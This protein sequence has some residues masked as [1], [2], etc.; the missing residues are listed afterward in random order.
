[1]NR[2]LAI[3]KDGL[4]AIFF[5]FDGVLAESMNVKTEAFAKLFESYGKEIV[6]KVVKYHIENGGISRYEKIKYYYSEYL[7]KPLS[8][9]ELNAIAKQF[10]DL[11]VQKVIEAPEVRGV[12]EFLE[13][14]YKKI[15]LYVV[16]GTP[17]DELMLI[18]KK[19]KMKKYFKGIFGAPEAKSSIIKKII[20]DI[21]YNQERV[22]Y[23]GDSLSDYRDAKKAKIDFLG[24]VPKGVR[25]QFPKNILTFPDFEGWPYDLQ[26]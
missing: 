23:I 7:S 26:K 5:D 17:Q 11:V 9:S 24:R 2:P 21:S 1:M 14:Y 13:R 16:S 25:S 8:N 12:K 15:D 22:L 10:S 18:I 4:Q 6:N 20:S 3:S 19:R